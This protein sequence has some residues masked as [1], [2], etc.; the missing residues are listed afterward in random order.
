M[1]TQN[2]MTAALVSAG[3]PA[4]PLNK[5][6]W[7][8]LRDHP[9]KTC[10]EISTATGALA[11]DVSV[12]LL[13]LHRRKMVARNK[14]KRRA[15]N[16]T[17]MSL[18]EYTTCIREYELLPRPT[19]ERGVGRAPSATACAAIEKTAPDIRILEKTLEPKPPQ[20]QVP[21]DTLKFRRELPYWPQPINIKDLPL[22]EALRLYGELKAVFGDRA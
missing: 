8:W 22:S 3:F 5:R 12:A 21:A 7:L 18:F 13:D 15:V 2:T 9:G 19:E 14:T 16:G 4:V 11:G 20:E 10:R 1:Q 6:V 17:R